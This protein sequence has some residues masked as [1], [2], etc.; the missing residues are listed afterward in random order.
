MTC[1][2]TR[3]QL[4]AYLDGELDADRG[5]VVRGHLRT[6]EACRDIAEREAVLRDGLRALEPVDPPPSLWANVQA[7]LADAEVAEAQRPAWRRALARWARL[8]SPPRL[9][10]AGTALAAAFVLVWWRHTPAP[11]PVLTDQGKTVIKSSP[12]PVPVAVQPLCKSI[13]PTPPAADVTADIDGEADRVTAM[14]CAEAENQLRAAAA[15][16]LRADQRKA[17]DARV[18]ELRGRIDK[19]ADARAAHKALREL[20]KFT[21]QSVARDDVAL[22]E[23]AP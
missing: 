20:I 11:E 2:D 1:S 22:A 16:P 3:K 6:C 17:F 18:V 12:P 15:A 23:V 7:K 4:T 5:T 10:L 8:V 19:A 14:Y 9:A 21:A 13:V